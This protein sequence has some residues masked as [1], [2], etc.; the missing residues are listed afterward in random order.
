MG[1]PDFAVPALEKI[2]EAGHDIV[3]VVTQPDK[4]KGRGKKLKISTVVKVW[5]YCLH[6][7]SIF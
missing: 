7:M 3:L 5:K 6:L 4:S 2:H 1:T